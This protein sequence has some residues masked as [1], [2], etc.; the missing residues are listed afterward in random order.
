MQLHSILCNC[1]VTSEPYN[2]R[3]GV[4]QGCV[5]APTLFS[6]YLSTL[7]C[8]AFPSPEG[9]A[10]H[11]RHNRNLFSLA[12]LR[13]KMKTDTGLICKLMFAKKVAFCTHSVLKLQETCNAF[14]AS[15]NMFGLEIST[16]KIVILV[17]N[18]SPSCIWISGELLTILD[19]F[20]Y[21]DSTITNTATLHT[22]VSSQIGKAAKI[23]RKLRQHVWDNKYLIINTKVKIY[24]T[25]M[26]IV[27]TPLL[28]WDMGLPCHHWM[29]A[30]L[31][32]HTLPYKAS[33]HH[34][35]GQSSQHGYS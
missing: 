26:C 1:K 3:C 10:L 7:L 14:S 30:E 28:K 25:C 34:L 2:L 18:G 35:E 12:C 6:I 33:R 24:E 9:I 20:C 16:K 29:Q 32:Q 15:C 27:F 17:T 11:T 13:A 21:L 23:F 19:Q 22:K 5:M 8:H 31:I 4:K